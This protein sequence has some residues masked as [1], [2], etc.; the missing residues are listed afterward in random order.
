MA[1]CDPKE[2]M[3]SP[4]NAARLNAEKHFAAAGKSVD[5][6]KQAASLARAAIDAHTLRLRTLRLEKEHADRGA[7]SPA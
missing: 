5:L 1:A 4:K 2:I 3:H 6:V 7:I